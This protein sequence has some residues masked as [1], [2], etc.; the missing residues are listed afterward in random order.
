[1]NILTNDFKVYFQ[2]KKQQKITEWI[3]TTNYEW[4]QTLNQKKKK[5]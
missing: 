1:M 3:N 2:Q 5:K 4:T